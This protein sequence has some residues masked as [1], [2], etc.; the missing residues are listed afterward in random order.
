MKGKNSRKEGKLPL[1]A[2]PTGL[3]YLKEVNSSR[4]LRQ[5][6]EEG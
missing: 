2:L 6:Q 4:D 1:V 3:R 5:L